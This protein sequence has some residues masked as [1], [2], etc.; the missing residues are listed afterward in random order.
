M[1]VAGIQVERSMRGHPIYGRVDFR[2]HP[3][4]ISVFEEK[5]VNMLS[6]DDLKNPAITGILPRGYMSVDECFDNVEKNI[7]EYCKAN[8]IH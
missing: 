6:K 2:K 4:M 3:D 1:A 7:I 5:G 8:D